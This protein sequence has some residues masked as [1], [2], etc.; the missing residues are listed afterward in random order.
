[1]VLSGRESLIRLIG[2]RRRFLP[3][4]HSILSDPNPN[5]I[6]AVEPSR[7]DK[8]DNVQCPVCGHNLPGDD[9][10]MI[11]SH[12]DACLSLSQPKPIIVTK[13][14][15]SQRTLLQFN[16]TKP[17]FENDAPVLPPQNDKCEEQN[18]QE[19]EL[20][21]NHEAELVSTISAT[22]SSSSP[23]NGGV[24]HDYEPD[25]LGA[26]LETFIVGRKYADQEEL[27]AGNAIFLLRDPQNVNDP[28]AIKVHF[29]FASISCFIVSRSSL[30]LLV[31]V[32]SV[33]SA[34]CKSLGFIPRELAQF[35]SPLIDN[36][37]LEFQILNQIK[38]I[39]LTK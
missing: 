23:S 19:E 1:M 25:V 18:C 3:N 29:F 10:R 32:V 27:C 6:Q 15:L 9:H 36:Y 14:K 31:Q 38:E 2:K 4:R 12:L 20:P 13:R 39:Q 8:N 37:G 21:E 5:P 35:L 24:P 16:F 11:N 33:D 34:C 7:P 22:S 17:R 28:N 30:F 26:T